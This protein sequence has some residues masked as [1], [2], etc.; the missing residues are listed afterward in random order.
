[1]LI[2]VTH[3]HNDYISWLDKSS[4]NL[5]FCLASQLF[6]KKQWNTIELEILLGKIVMSHW[7]CTRTHVNNFPMRTRW[8]VWLC[9][10]EN[11]WT[12]SWLHDSFGKQ[13]PT[14]NNFK[15]HGFDKM[16]TLTLHKDNTLREWKPNVGKT[17]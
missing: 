3:K 1:M 5:S 4:A 10:I 8:H 2:Q 9:N 13:M 11:K 7:L 14:R 12:M 15:T 16:Q 17:E 6:K